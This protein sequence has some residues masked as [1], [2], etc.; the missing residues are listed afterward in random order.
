MDWPASE[1]RRGDEQ[2]E[3]RHCYMQDLV[4]GKF[5]KRTIQKKISG[6]KFLA[7]FSMLFAWE[8]EEEE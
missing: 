8:E 3:P 5:S 6:V 7:H 2:S 4:R 1:A